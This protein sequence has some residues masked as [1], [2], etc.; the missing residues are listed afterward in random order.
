VLSPGRDGHIRVLLVDSERMVI[1]ALGAALDAEDDIDVVALVGTI[2]DADRV[3]DQE[4]IDVA[5]VAAQLPDGDGITACRQLRAIRPL[6]PVLLLGASTEA[7][8]VRNAVAAGC[9]GF[10][11]RQDPLATLARSIRASAAGQTVFTP[12]AVHHLAQSFR[13]VPTVAPQELSEREL[14]VLRLLA[15]GLATE[16]IAADL[17]LSVHTVRNHIRHILEKIGAH[18]RLEAVAVATH[19]GIIALE[20]P[21]R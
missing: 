20:S 3:V 16:S 4:E 13:S 5:V 9:S 2:G 8:A 19:E 15:T 21:P 14:E 1:E 18:S 11:A 6:V 12:T 10:V 7:G 17:H